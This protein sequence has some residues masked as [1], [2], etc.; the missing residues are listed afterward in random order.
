LDCII[1]TI[2]TIIILFWNSWRLTSLQLGYLVPE[3]QSAYTRHYYS[4]MNMS[5]NDNY[6]NRSYKQGGFIPTRE[7]KPH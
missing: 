7:S 5:T 4:K 3:A 1:N 2:I 6:V